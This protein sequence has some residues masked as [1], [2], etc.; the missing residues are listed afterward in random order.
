MKYIIS[1]LL[2]VFAL[3]THASTSQK[4]PVVWSFIPTSTQALYIKAILDEAN[5]LQNKYEFV[6]EVAQ[7]AGGYVATQ[8]VQND[9][10]AG[11]FTLLANT[12][13]FF[14]RPYLYPDRQYFDDFKPVM[15]VARSN[16]V[17]VTKNTNIETMASR[18]K[19]SFATAG[20]GSATHVFA[21][22][23]AKELRRKY[24]NVDV[25]MVHYKNAP[26]AFM[27]VMG[28]HTDA[29]FEF[30]GNAFRSALPETRMIGFTGNTPINGVPTL[31]SMGYHGMSNL[32]NLFAIFAPADTPI[33]VTT[34]LQTLF[35]KAEK[36][37]SVQ[38]LYTRDYATKEVKY[39]QF[40][41]LNVWYKQTIKEF[42]TH[43]K[44]IVV[45]N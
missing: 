43:T 38:T 30:A 42:E 25:V 29:T 14:I 37:E 15:F 44:G 26:D 12:A 35:L 8:K 6:F 41:D 10:K 28:G 32:S 20:A 5:R 16:A 11:K 31:S 33:N 27:S 21:E 7:G 34:E 9:N 36:A 39:T 3:T 19:I 17:L 18:N 1:L 2:F 45:T 40:S 4:V 22:S 23:F 13:A 24:P